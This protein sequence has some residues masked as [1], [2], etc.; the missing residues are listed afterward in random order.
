MSRKGALTSEFLIIGPL[1]VAGIAL[2][3][4]LIARY[5]R[6][7]IRRGVNAARTRAPL[8][9]RSGRAEQRSRTVGEAIGSLWVAI[10]SVLATLMILQQIGVNLGPLIAGAGIAGVA[11][12]FGAQTLIKDYISGLFILLEDQYS[13]G[14]VITLGASTGTVEDVNLRVTRIRSADGTVWFVPNGEVRQVGNLS[15]E[16]SR[17]IVD[18]T[19]AYDNDIPSVLSHLA[20]EAAAFAAEPRWAPLILE[21]PEVEGVQSMGNEGVTIRI[22]AKTA[23]RKQWEVARE[24]RARVTD[25]MR[26]EGLRGPGRTVRVSSGTLDGGV[27]V[28][29]PPEAL[30]DPPP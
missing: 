28:P 20:A 25:R 30:D 19:V 13:V 18:V 17:A 5:G 4:Y 9:V 15:M 14:D 6:R 24:L 26:R 16:W 3:A 1:R 29:A 10:V 12:A 2:L 27:P 23:P 11:L 22:V 8:R 21:A 7:I